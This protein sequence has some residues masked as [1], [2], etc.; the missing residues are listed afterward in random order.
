[1]AEVVAI[2]LTACG[3]HS[4]TD[5]MAKVTLVSTKITDAALCCVIFTGMILSASLETAETVVYA[6]GGDFYGADQ[7]LFELKSKLFLLSLASSLTR[8]GPL[9]VLMA[10]ALYLTIGHYPQLRTTLIKHTVQVCSMLCAAWL[11]WCVVLI[12]N[13]QPIDVRTFAQFMRPSLLFILLSLSAFA[14][15]GRAI[16]QSAKF[17]LRKVLRYE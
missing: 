9:I 6:Y 1:M 17:E 2:P 3:D 12:H 14:N 15:G 5:V 11:V 16:A 4:D 8:H 13:D 7:I 10:A